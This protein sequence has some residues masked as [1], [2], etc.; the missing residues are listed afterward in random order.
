MSLVAV[1]PMCMRVFFLIFFNAVSRCW[2]SR[3]PFIFIFLR[4][5]VGKKTE[6][7]RRQG[8]KILLTL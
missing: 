2:R 1:F 7:V 6:G 4:V 5:E 3:G 8:R